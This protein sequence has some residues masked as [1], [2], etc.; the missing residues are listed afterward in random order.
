M[1]PN[2]AHDSHNSGIMPSSAKVLLVAVSTP[3]CSATSGDGDLEDP[4][5]EEEDDAAAASSSDMMIG[6]ANGRRQ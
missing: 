1:K 2:D 5:A 6:I 4:A 3:F